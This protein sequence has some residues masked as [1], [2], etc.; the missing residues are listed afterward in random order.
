MNGYNFTD[1][2]RKV[3]QIAREEAARLHH[4]YVGT[5]HI[6]LALVREGEGVASAVLTNL[7]VDPEG[8]RAA[9]Q[10]MLKEGK[11]LNPSQDLPYTSRAKKI[12]EFAMSEARELNH[13]YIGTEHLLL[14]VLREAKGI[15]AQALLTVGV[16]LEMARAETL[17]LLGTD[18]RLLADRQ[19]VSLGPIDQRFK[20]AIALIELHRVRFGDYPDSLAALQ[21]FGAY[22]VASFRAVRYEKLPDGYA[23]DIVTPKG[24]KPGLSYPADFWRGLG[25]RRTNVDRSS[26]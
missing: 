2:V 14:G 8:L 19:V 1:R 6:L 13:Y 7:N 5:E 3:L 10:G 12:L 22:D 18:E 23:L 16:T 9:I 11:N 24:E 20:T 21:F 25:I 17:R 15:A 4:A 26:P